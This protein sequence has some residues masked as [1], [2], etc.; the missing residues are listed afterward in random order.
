MPADQDRF[1]VTR[2]IL[3][4][5]LGGQ[6]L[7]PPAEIEFAAN[8][9]GKPAVSEAQNPESIR[10]NVSHS[11]DYALLAFAKG[12]DVGVDVER[13]GG[14]RV[15]GDL[16]A[17]VFS[18]AEFQRF[19]LLAEC[20]R[21][22]TFFQIWT[23]KESVLKAAGHGL[24]VGLEFVE[25][26]LDPDEPKLLG[27]PAEWGGDVDQW[28]LRNLAIGDDAYA[29]AIAVRERTPVIEMKRFE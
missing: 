7:L 29:A 21:E 17:R 18:P 28:T 13:I 16:A 19:S 27:S 10:F 9:H 25:I 20:D 23:L 26:A 2:G 22:K 4:T 1:A 12:V 8:Q 6:L 14:D 3:R 5:L 11:G 15:V 24:S